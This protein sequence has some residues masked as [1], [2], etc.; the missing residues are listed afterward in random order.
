MHPSL[1][2]RHMLRPEQVLPDHVDIIVEMIPDVIQC[3]QRA[4]S[5]AAQE[6]F[7]II[8]EEGAPLDDRAS[9]LFE[10]I[11]GEVPQRIPGEAFE[12]RRIA[13]GCPFI[14]PV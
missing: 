7:L 14:S 13:V 10:L 3:L 4:F 2:F 9:L 8:L 5:A 6:S 11:A 1:H 12:R